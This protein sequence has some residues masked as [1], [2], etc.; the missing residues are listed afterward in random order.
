MFE[1]HSKE[2]EPIKKIIKL[3]T[4]NKICFRYCYDWQN[5]VYSIQYDEIDNEKA[6]CELESISIKYNL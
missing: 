1:L 2:F 5:E 3:F 6:L 4:A